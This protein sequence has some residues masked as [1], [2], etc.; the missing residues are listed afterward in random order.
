[1][2]QLRAGSV[3]SFLI[4]LS[5]THTAHSGRNITI[6]LKTLPV[7]QTNHLSMICDASAHKQLVRSKSAFFPYL[8]AVFEEYIREWHHGQSQE[9]Q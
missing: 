9:C 3:F 2:G 1:M 5:M 6:L 4:N 8:F 7:I